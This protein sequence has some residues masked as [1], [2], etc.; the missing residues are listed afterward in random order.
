MSLIGGLLDEFRQDPLRMMCKLHRENGDIAQFRLGPKRFRAVFDPEMLKEIMITKSDAFHKG[1]AFGEVKRLTGEGLVLS[2]GELHKKQRRIMQPK[3]TRSHVQRY[4]EQMTASTLNHIS[5]WGEGGQRQ[6]TDELFKI[7]FDIIARSM[8]SFDSSRQ[9]EDI[10]KAFDSVIR[11]ASDKIRALVRVPLAIPTAQNREYLSALRVL[12]T[13]VYDLITARRKQSSGLP[14]QD[15]MSILMEAVDEGEDG[16][17]MNDTQ[18][19]DELITMFLA[20]HETTAHTLAWAIDYIMKHPEVEEKLVREWTSVLGGRPPQSE[21]FPA[22]RYT[23][24]VLWETLRLKP[25]GYMTT[26]TAVAPVTIGSLQ[27]KPGDSF[28]ISPYPLHMSKL[29]FEQPEQ[30]KPERFENDFVKTLPTMAFFPFGAG[31]RSCIGNHYAMLEM[32]MI[33]A[34]IGQQYRLEPAPGYTQAEVE[35]LFTL[36]PKGGIHVVASRRSAV[37]V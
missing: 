19:R 8:F 20:G 7:T 23:Q 9:L 26:R 29:Y 21:D 18:L 33:L 16:T 35:A 30:F 22:L 4:A 11:I 5:Q 3:F 28:M 17:G 6:L 15:L 25:A 2:E 31:P 36:R 14:S 10:G 37:T 12:D 34:T 1:G 32:V 27:L 24:N 13:V